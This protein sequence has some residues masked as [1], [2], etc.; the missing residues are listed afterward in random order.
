[1]KGLFS[2]IAIHFFFHWF[3]GSKIESYFMT[4]KMF[5]SDTS[6]ITSVIS[7]LVRA[8]ITVSIVKKKLKIQLKLF[9]G[10]L[11]YDQLIV[12]LQRF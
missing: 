1:M 5:E 6:E 4:A 3:K 8:E 2:R 10:V 11:L 12:S 7:D 9:T